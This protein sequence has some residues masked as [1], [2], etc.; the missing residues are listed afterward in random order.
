M[1][2]ENQCLQLLE[3]CVG[4]SSEMLS[5][6]QKSPLMWSIKKLTPYGTDKNALLHRKILQ[7]PLAETLRLTLTQLVCARQS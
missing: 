7:G 1:T 3:A 5:K 6:L 4:S 2:W